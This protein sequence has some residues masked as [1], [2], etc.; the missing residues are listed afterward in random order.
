MESSVKE[1]FNVAIELK[2]QQEVIGYAINITE[3][4]LQVLRGNVPKEDCDCMKDECILDTLKINGSNLSTLEK[5]LNEIARK[6]IG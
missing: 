4:I 2:R 6:V 5:N 3:K 1:E